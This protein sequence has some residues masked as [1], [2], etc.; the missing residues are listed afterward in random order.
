MRLCVISSVGRGGENSTFIYGEH[1]DARSTA[2]GNTRFFTIFRTRQEHSTSRGGI[3]ECEYTTLQQNAES[4]F[5]QRVV[6]GSDRVMGEMDRD[7]DNAGV[8]VD[9]MD[10]ASTVGQ[11]RE[12][13]RGITIGL[14]ELGP[15]DI[16]RPDRN[17]TAAAHAGRNQCETRGCW[18]NMRRVAVDLRDSAV[19]ATLAAVGITCFSLQSRT[20]YWVLH[21][22]W[23]VLVMTAPYY[24]IRGRQVFVQ[25]MEAWITHRSNSNSETG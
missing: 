21:S 7:S 15:D 9:Q 11:S 10:E 23:H 5:D 13:G 18:R 17:V 8:G 20:T 2:D 16:D 25:R 19:G 14:F 12:E 6:V 1:T 24:L 4:A 22:M 3:S